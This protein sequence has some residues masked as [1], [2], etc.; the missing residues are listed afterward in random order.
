[1]DDEREPVEPSENR[2]FTS[3]A[4]RPATWPS[5]SPSPRACLPR[6]RSLR[7]VVPIPRATR[8]PSVRR[9]AINTVQQLLHRPCN[10]ATI[11]AS[12]A[13][14]LSRGSSPRSTAAARRS[15]SA[16]HAS[17][18]S[19]SSGCRKFE[20]S[21]EQFIGVRLGHR[22]PSIARN[23]G[24]ESPSPADLAKRRICPH[25]PSRPP[26]AATLHRPPPNRKLQQTKAVLPTDAVIP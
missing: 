8:A 2:V 19:V 25:H 9:G 23:A 13:S 16:S 4:A 17:L 12:T 21:F 15:T 11:R 5:P 24:H 7:F 10:S 6:G 22:V 14:Q 26:S 3:R 1:M 18:H 20:R